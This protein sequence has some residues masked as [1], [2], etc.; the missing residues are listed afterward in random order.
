MSNTQLQKS[1]NI[2]EKAR[3]TGFY[4]VIAFYMLL[5]AINATLGVVGT[6]WAA[7]NAGA[8][9]AIAGSIWYLM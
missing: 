7:V 3:G 8:V 6:E 2:A 4:I 1:N 5:I 9:I